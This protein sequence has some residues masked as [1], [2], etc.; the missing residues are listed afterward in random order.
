[1]QASENAPD[2]AGKLDQGFQFLRTAQLADGSWSASPE[3]TSGCWVTSLACIVL[4]ADAHAAVS[5][6]LKWLC[7]DWPRDS[8]PWR[9]FLAR[10]S[11]ERKISAQDDSLQGWGWTPHTSSWVEPTSFALILLDHT[12]REMWPQ[13]ADRRREMARRM[14]YDRMCPGGGW[15]C[16]NPMVYGVAGEPLIVPT[17]WA[18]LAIRDDPNRAEFAMSLDWL[19]KNIDDARGAGSLAQARVCL[20]ICGRKWP[21]KGATLADFYRRNDFLRSVPVAAWSCLASCQQHDWLTSGTPE[22]FAEHA[23]A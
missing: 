19:A 18:L 7:D 9:R 12:P 14:L 21:T 3:V 5:S 13:A 6:G 20:E 22:K 17:V 15:N 16:G 4:P 11:F 10:F 2:C 23:K 1:L 8:A